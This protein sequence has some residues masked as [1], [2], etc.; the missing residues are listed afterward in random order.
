MRPTSLT[1]AFIVALVL[2]A[3]LSTSAQNSAQQLRSEIAV[4][5]GDLS[6]SGAVEIHKATEHACYVFLGEDH[7]IAEV[8]QFADALYNELHRSNHFSA[9]ALEVSPSVA[10]QLTSELD[11]ENPDE[12][13]ADFLRQ[14]P[15]TVPF[16]NTQEEFRFL[17]N[18]KARTGP[19]FE[20]IGFDQEFLGAAKFLLHRIGKE[21][22]PS[23]LR[24]QLGELE[25]EERQASV[26]AAKSGN[27][28]DLFLLSADENRLE[29]FADGLRA[30]ALDGRAVDDWL[31]S[32][33]VYD[34]FSKNNYASN[35]MRDLLMKHNFVEMHSGRP[36]CGILFK[37]G[38]NHGFRGVSPLFTRELGNFLAETADVYSTGGVHIM[39][40]G[41]EGQALDFAG[42]GKPMRVVPYAPSGSGGLSSLKEFSDVAQREQSWSLF[43]LRRLRG[44]AN[45]S[46]DA[47]MQRL[48]YG[49]DFL[50]VVPHPTASHEIGSNSPK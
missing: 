41:S 44:T 10:R 29:Q 39:I 32:R 48:I 19:N 17:K 47:E 24:K 22:L 43:D 23:D 31:A 2:N 42:V 33:H 49:Y 4:T 12:E 26:K 18:S 9:V 1:I 11:S 14:Y 28:E 37:A 8:A 13:H 38:S 5:N 27:A 35:T 40:V 36:P 16:Y 15:I 21:H 30:R 7:G 34:M 3:S 46:D 20:L 6:G 45:A 50:V 25:E